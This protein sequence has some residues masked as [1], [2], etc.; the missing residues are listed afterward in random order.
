[1]CS[2]DSEGKSN[3]TGVMWVSKSQSLCHNDEAMSCL[4]WSTTW[5]A[6][7]LCGNIIP[8]WSCV[9]ILLPL[10]IKDLIQDREE[11]VGLYYA[12]NN[13]MSLTFLSCG[14]YSAIG[15]HGELDQGN[16]GQCRATEIPTVKPLASFGI[17]LW[18][19]NMQRLGKYLT[20]CCSEDDWHPSASGVDL[21]RAGAVSAK[22][23]FKKVSKLW[24]SFQTTRPSSW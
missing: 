20:R 7:R 17:E 14:P 16:T 12:A 4:H 5:R 18:H 23:S 13:L 9:A 2:D 3:R 8:T 21:A 22:R 1:M 6:P 10:A 11:A 15:K 24:R 19:H